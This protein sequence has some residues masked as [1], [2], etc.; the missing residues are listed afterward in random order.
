MS[1]MCH[2]EIAPNERCEDTCNSKIQNI[3]FNCHKNWFKKIQKILVPKSTKKYVS[4]L[5]QHNFFSYEQMSEK[6]IFTSRVVLKISILSQRVYR[7]VTL[8]IQGDQSLGKI[9]YFYIN[10]ITNLLNYIYLYFCLCT[11][12]WLWIIGSFDNM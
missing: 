1:T 8:T 6:V 10:I 4:F 12:R 3:A 11:M 7:I 2:N 9:S 5:N